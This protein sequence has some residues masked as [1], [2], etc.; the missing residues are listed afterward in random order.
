MRTIRLGLLTLLAL[1]VLPAVAAAKPD[2]EVQLLGINDFHGH[3]E[4]TTPGTI[5]PDPASPRVPAGGA[6]Y[7]ATHLRQAEQTNRNTLI[8]S[9]GDLIGASPLLSALFHDEPTIE[10]MNKIG[11]D[12]NAVGNHE[13]DEGS[14]ELRRMQRGGCHPVDGCL[15]GDGFAGAK[16]RFLAANVVDEDSG[17]T[18]FPAY[19]IKEFNGIKVGFIGM[20]LEGTPDIVSPSG[21]AGLDFLDEAETANRYARELR[22]RHGVRAIVVLLHEG[23]LQT[24]PGGINDCN[25]ISGPIVDIVERTTSQ[26]D[27]FVT[28]HTH[29]A[30]NCVIDGRPVTSASSF[31][32]LLTDIDLTLDRRS[33]DVVEVAANNQIVTQ[34]VFK[35]MDMSQLIQRYDA[36]A[37]PLRDRVIG[38][39]TAD[40][41]RTPD[42]SLEH[43]AGNLI[44]DAQLAATSSPDTGTAV[45]AFMNPGGV[46]SEFLFAQSG[47]EGDGNVTYGEAFTVQP[48]GNSLVTMTLTGA[49]IL[50]VLKSQW[51]GQDFPRVLLPSASVAYTFDQSVASGL[52]GQPCE[53]APNPVT[54][55]SIGGTPVD[56]AASYRITVNSFL[57]D[58]GD[59]FPVLRAGTDR[60]GGAVDT[61][62]L[63]AYL[64]PSLTGTPIAPPALDRIDVVP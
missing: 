30:Y 7:L 45:A 12:L 47:S 22:R 49:Q 41:T 42:D 43:A 4:S 36:I 10:A 37:A 50:D 34:N 59:R 53:G 62:A 2:V 18:L 24:A 17:R 31:G 20:T 35:A 8:V 16:F 33:R 27:L 61:D 55:L 60:L 58:G 29:T 48:F 21:V 51:C 46:R 32:R 15:D 5:A 39:I 1:L 63:E 13:F 19:S 9:A 54:S 25:G 52:V 28:G 14:A 56:P 26:V 38:R 57:A 6:E 44:A 64:A 23:G 11:L 40:I 3:L